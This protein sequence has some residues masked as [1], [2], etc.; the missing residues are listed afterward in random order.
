MNLKNSGSATATVDTAVTLYN[1]KPDTYY[2]AGGFNWDWGTT[3]ATMEPGATSTATITIPNS[4]GFKSGMT[5][6][7]MLHTTGG[8]D[9][10]K[11]ITLP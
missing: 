10:P 5:I 7:M 6:E 11:V 1:G 9:Y 4:A 8:K 3:S 2:V